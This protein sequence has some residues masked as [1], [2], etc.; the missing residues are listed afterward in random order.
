MPQSRGDSSR[1]PNQSL[2]VIVS[3]TFAVIPAAGKSRRMGRPKLT[4]PLGTQTVIEAVVTA[5]TKG[6]V[7]KLVV[8][9]PPGGRELRALAEK[10]GAAVLELKSDTAEMRD[11]IEHGLHWLE[12]QFRP[13]TADG[14]LLLPADHPCVDPTIVQQILRARD[15]VTEQS[16]IVPVFEGRRGHPVWLSWRHVAVIRGLPKGL[17]LNSYLRQQ[18]GKT[19]ELPVSSPSILWDLD[20][21]EDYEALQTIFPK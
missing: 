19:L 11:T 21:P 16:I 7:E 2:G 14:F 18:T 9:V 4:L 20:T 8:V 10:A 3:R 1:S 13:T 6:G 12:Q 5:V 15:C 17:G